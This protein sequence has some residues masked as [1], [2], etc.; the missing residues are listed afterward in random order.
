MTKRV[1]TTII[2]LVMTIQTA[3]GHDT[4]L[5]KREGEF[6]VLRGH[7]LKDIEA[8]D[9]G[10][11]T[12]AK[13]I[14]QNSNPL[15]V[16]IVDKKDNAS[17]QVAGNPCVVGALYDS[18]YWLKTT[19][20]WKK[21]TK[22]E[23]IGRYTI[24]ESIN[25]KQYCKYYAGSCT[26]GLKPLGQDFEIVPQRDPSTLRQGDRCS[27][28]V[29]LKG[30]PVEGAA[31]LVGGGHESATSNQIKTDKDGKAEIQINRGGLQ[32]VKATYAIPTKDD[33]DADTLAFQ[34]TITF[35][36]E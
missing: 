26:A 32:M 16:A 2:F 31:I 27:F 6:V 19:E 36:V 23:G 29:F 30:T 25:S 21:A 33:P 28:W 3:L 34:A 5:E 24:V 12:E 8:Y 20:G 14:D 17:L 22:R 4:W 9:P 11:I 15:P 35:L 18:G 10:K 13:A 1:F 7:D